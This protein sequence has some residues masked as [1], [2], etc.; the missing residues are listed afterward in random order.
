MSTQITN[1]D[2]LNS[3]ISR[4]KSYT[5]GKVATISGGASYAAFTGAAGLAS[6]STGLVPAPQAG[7]NE[8]FLCGNGTWATIPDNYTLPIA[9]ASTLGGVKIG[10]GLSMVGDTLTVVWNTFS[11]GSASSTVEG[12]F[13]LEED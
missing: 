2:Q 4:A 3:A 5:D 9:G 10:A 8:K 6:G 1:I 12:A 7:D 13:W 11:I